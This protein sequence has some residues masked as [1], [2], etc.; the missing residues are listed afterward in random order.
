MCRGWGHT[1]ALGSPSATTIEE[2]V[3]RGHGLRSRGKQTVLRTMTMSARA[4]TMGPCSGGLD[5]G[6]TCEESTSVRGG[7]QLRSRVR[8]GVEESVNGKSPP[9]NLRLYQL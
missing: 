7:R 5:I 9:G 1:A 8:V 4:H 3:L 6:L 2:K